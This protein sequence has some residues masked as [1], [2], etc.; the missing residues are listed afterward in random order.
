MALWGGGS[1][2]IVINGTPPVDGRANVFRWEPEAAP[3]LPAG[4]FVDAPRRIESFDTSRARTV[5]GFVVGCGAGGC[6]EECDDQSCQDLEPLGNVC[7]YDHEP[8][9]FVD[10]TITTT[11]NGT[12]CEIDTTTGRVNG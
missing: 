4:E 6:P 8:E 2:D 1:L 3:M 5:E 9:A 12:D 7:S 11:W 10:R